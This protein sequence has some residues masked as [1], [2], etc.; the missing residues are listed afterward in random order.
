MKNS[1]REKIGL[2]VFGLAFGMICLGCA[3]TSPKPEG[4]VPNLEPAPALQETMP[5]PPQTLSAAEEAPP[6]RFKPV[7]A[8]PKPVPKATLEA[9]PKPK[10]TSYVHTVKWSGETISIIADWYTGDIE[11]WKALAQ[12]NPNIKANRILAGNKILIPEIL[13]KTREPMPKQF[14]DRFYSKLRKEKAQPQPTETQEEE[15]KLIGP[16]KSPKK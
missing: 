1:F 2:W 16:K 11:K 14:V 15:I 9:T 6:S 8:P 3:S 4:L 12:A 5:A 7:P 10:E 13:M